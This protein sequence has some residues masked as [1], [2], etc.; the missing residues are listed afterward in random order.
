MN[1]TK[2][3]KDLYLEKYK[4]MMKEIEDDISKWNGIPCAWIGR[5]N[6][7]IT[8]PPRA[9]YRFSAIPIKYQWNFV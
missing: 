7:K 9:I 5:V 8:V 6:V 1:L 4:I 2:D 3:I